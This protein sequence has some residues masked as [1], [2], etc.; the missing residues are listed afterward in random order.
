MKTS[1]ANPNNFSRSASGYH[2][3]RDQNKKWPVQY[4]RTISLTIGLKERHPS[5]NKI[6]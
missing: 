4:E 1:T 2:T 6:S 5:E 3:A